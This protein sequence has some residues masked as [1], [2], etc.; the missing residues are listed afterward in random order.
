[1]T[2]LPQGTVTFL[3]SD[4]EGSTRL[5]QRLGDQPWSELLEAHRMLLRRTFA[6]H[7]GTEVDTQGDA[8][9]VV[10]TRAA[11]AVACAAAAQQALLSYAWPVDDAVK[12]RIGIHTGEAVVRDHCYIGQEVH[13]ASRICNAAHGGQ[14]VLSQTTAEL[15]RANL[16]AGSALKAIGEHRLKDLNEPQR[17][18][19]LVAPGLPS[20]FAPLRGFRAPT[21]LPAERSTFIGRSLE[22]K[23][24]RS[25]LASCRLITLAGIG[26]SGKTRLAL[27]VG[28]LELDHFPDGVFFVDLSAVTDPESVAP[29]LALACGVN[30]GDS[31]P[32]PSSS[33]CSRLVSALEPRR[34]LLLVDNCEHQLSAVSELLDQLLAGC[35]RLALLATSREPLG[36]EG[37]MVVQVPSLPFPQDAGT[38]MV[39]DAMLLFIERA[40]SVNSSFLVDESCMPQIAEICRRLDG[41]PLAIELAAARVSHLS[42]LQIAQRL[43]DR[44]RMLCGGRRRALRQQTLLASL[45]WSHDLLTA[46]ERIVFRRL[47]VFAGGFTLEA[48]EAVCSGN[49]IPSGAV[50]DLLAS[51]LAKSLLSIGE[52]RGGNSRYRLLE[53][54]RL[55]SLEKLGAADEALAL[56]SRHRDYF[57]AWLES[58]EMDDRIFGTDSMD[59]IG[60]EFEN[61]RG[62]I[63]FCWS[64]DRIDLVV[65][66]VTLM[67]GFWVTSAS[68]RIPMA[69]L[70]RALGREERLPLELRVAGH[71]LLGWLGILAIDAAPA[72]VGDS[73]Q[74]AALAAG[75]VGAFSTMACTLRS[76]ACAVIGSIP[77]AA[78]SLIEEAHHRA[79]AAVVNARACLSGA[80]I[81]FTESNFGQVEMHLGNLESAAHWYRASF[82]SC[83]R[84]SFNVWLA[85]MAAS[86]LTTS[87]HLLGRNDEAL[88]AALAYLALAASTGSQLSWL[89]GHFIEVVPA[90]FVGGRRVQAEREL[91]SRANVMRY[92]GVY[93]APNHFLGVAGVVEF[94]RGRPDRAARLL[95]AARTVCGA[96]K[97]LISFRTPGSLAYYRHYQPLV[98]DA[99]GPDAAKRARDEGRRMSLDDAFSYALQ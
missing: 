80:W 84:L 85:P 1:M 91:R 33:L 95:A 81:A 65:R 64:D 48:A 92:N 87:L 68:H 30:P 97:D 13:R 14:V 29:T 96:D 46:D 38:G 42:V 52:G 39:T 83:R 6:T 79:E 40:K 9:F 58:A 70:E 75:R 21:N 15:I 72:A 94:L 10:F 5:A 34:A 82:A 43:E 7:A 98:R 22:V 31:V 32:G 50:L 44:L 76:F 24:L 47:A 35:A 69:M 51:L 17:L 41:I 71:A 60:Q 12:V 99:L 63:D 62:A 26:G 11:D 90:L 19:Q 23:A 73:A 59:A 25:A 78:P 53:T 55:Y 3:F 28:A 61:L 56:R 77:G 57:L 93:K 89:D 2:S 36:L 37:E 20:E 67:A 86:G 54:V 49:G 45:D 27:R 88:E 8:F 18:F 4:I 66:M 16:P 74:A